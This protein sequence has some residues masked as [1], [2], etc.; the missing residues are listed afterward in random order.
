M[1]MKRFLMSWL[2]V[3]VCL[4]NC[5]PVPVAALEDELTIYL[6]EL[7]KINNELGTEYGFPTEDMLDDDGK[8]YS[9]LV[10]FYTQ[11][12]IEAFRTYVYEAHENATQV[13]EKAQIYQ[14]VAD[15]TLIQPR[16]YPKTQRFYYDPSSSEY[17]YISAILYTADGEERYSY[18]T[19]WGYSSSS[20]PHYKAYD[21]TYSYSEG[22]TWVNCTFSCYKVVSENLIYTTIYSVPVSFR[23]AYGDVYATL[24]CGEE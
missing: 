4:L 1:K 15:E 24:I 17:L 16:A 6:E 2:V 23:S 22:W 11:M 3:V 5:A 7:E 14:E 10:D 20:Y 21:M 19:D 13:D 18:L 9:D 12:S 8:T